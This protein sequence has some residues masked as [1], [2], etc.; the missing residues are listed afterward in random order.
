[1]FSLNFCCRSYIS[2]FFV[3]MDTTGEEE[4]VELVLSSE[5]SD[6]DNP[7]QEVHHEDGSVS[8]TLAGGEAESRV[9]PGWLTQIYLSHILSTWVC[10]LCV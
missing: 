4:T 7:V 9:R 1:M 2:L 8:I 5:I 6:Q 3:V 10:L